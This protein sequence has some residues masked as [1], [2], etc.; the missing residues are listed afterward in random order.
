MC[1][2]DTYGDP[3]SQT[4]VTQCPFNYYADIRITVKLC[5]KVC[6]PGQFADD[7]TKTCVDM[8]PLSNKTYGNN[9]T[10]KCV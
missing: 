6:S 3:T 8:C 9:K 7:L 4:C 1:S 5:V 10:N 2:G